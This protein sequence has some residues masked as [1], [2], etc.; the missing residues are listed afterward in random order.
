MQAGTELEVANKDEHQIKLLDLVAFRYFWSSRVFSAL[1]FQMTTV[2]VGWLIYEKTDSAYYL[3][4]IGLC[5]FLPILL[6]TFVVGHAADRFDRRRIVAG[7]QFVEC[8][9]LLFLCIGAIEDRLQVTSIFASV[10]VIGAARSFE[11]PT[12]SATLP[13][14]IPFSLLPRALSISSSAMQTATILGP[15]IGGLLYAFGPGLP[16]GVASFCFLIAALSMSRI[17][18]PPRLRAQEPVTLRSVFSG[19]SFIAS[20]PA[21]LGTISL[22]LFAVLLGGITSLLPIF[23]RDVLDTGPWGL[24]LLR[25]APAIGALLMAVF[26]SRYFLDRNVGLKMFAAVMVFGLATVVFSVSSNLAV[27]ILALVALGGADNI[28]VVIRS[29]LVQLSTPDEMRGRVSSVNSLFIGTSN[30]L[31]EFESGIVA[32]L[33]GAVPAG[34][35][36]GVGTIVVAVL[37]MRLF[38]ELRRLDQLPARQNT[39]L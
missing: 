5:Q 32:G 2:A 16:L 19:V 33:V 28:S 38:P 34:I 25:S 35:I 26:F 4:L 23:A 8:A 13:S 18:I 22:D 39:P 15:S 27:S 30:Q 11:H 17:D 12:L 3:G 14:L 9:A 6:L 21:I 37:W 20:Q 31:G 10:F 7:C 24:G 29:S 36:G 1:A